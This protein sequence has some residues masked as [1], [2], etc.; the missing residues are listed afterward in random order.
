MEP[1]LQP[2][3]GLGKLEALHRRLSRFD[4]SA[5]NYGLVLFT[6]DHDI[7]KYALSNYEPLSSNRI[8]EQHLSGA[9]PTTRMLE[10][11]GKR[12]YILDVG[13]ARP[14]SC[15]AAGQPEKIE[16]A[17]KYAG[18]SSKTAELLS[19]GIN[20]HSRDFIEN[21][22]LTYDEVGLAITAGRDYWYI[23]S[24]NNFDIMG[25]GE[26]GV[27]NTLSSSAL[28]V[29]ATGSD[30]KNLVGRGSSSN[31]VI[32]R[33][34]SII[35][36]ALNNRTPKYDSILDLL[37]RFGGL[38]IAAMIGFIGQ[39]AENNMPIML[40][41]YVTAVA[42]FLAAIKDKRVHDIL[43]APSL[44]DQIGHGYILKQLGIEP[45]FDLNI[46]YGEGLAATFGLFLAESTEIFY[47]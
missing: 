35:E 15:E 45:M 13:L 18:F 2:Y 44:A 7:S 8:I 21:N 26:I 28:A 33:K 39:A 12:E 22:S 40:D 6:A 4:C 41:G 29:A 31:E 37:A 17:G 38:E 16:F 47:N 25:I 30:P 14:I 36:R 1:T 34:I 24:K 5:K 20:G 9:A 43:I 32:A 23:L 10:R 3:Q 27:G 11:L 46:N 42:A 19:Y